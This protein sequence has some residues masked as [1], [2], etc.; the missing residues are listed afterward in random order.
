MYQ[1][2][3]LLLL[4]TAVVDIVN[5]MLSKRLELKILSHMVVSLNLWNGTSTIIALKIVTLKS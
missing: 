1:Q 4:N 5:R 3:Y 2:Q